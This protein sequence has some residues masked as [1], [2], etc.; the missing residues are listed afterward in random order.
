[1][2]NQGASGGPSGQGPE[3]T[4]VSSLPLPP[5]A[6]INLYTDENIRR[7]RAPKPPPP[8]AQN[9]TYSMFGIPFHADDAII[10]PLESQVS[11]LVMYTLYLNCRLSYLDYE[12]S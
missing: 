8:P 4:Q 10:R 7:G 6:Y 5:A 9:D 11:S 12:Y 1:M 2:A 3:V